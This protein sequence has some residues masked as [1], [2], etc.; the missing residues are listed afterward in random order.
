MS[1][2]RQKLNPAQMY[3]VRYVQYLWDMSSSLHTF[4]V[5]FVLM[6]LHK[7]ILS[8]KKNRPLYTSHH[9]RPRAKSGYLYY[10]HAPRFIY[11]SCDCFLSLY[12]DVVLF[13]FSFFPKTSARKASVR[14][15]AWSV[16]FLLPLACVAVFRHPAC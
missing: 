4:L 5:I 1:L 8:N 14:E 12:I 16:Y 11:C 7:R 3:L 6:L 10:R 13:F 9:L 2:L 15:R